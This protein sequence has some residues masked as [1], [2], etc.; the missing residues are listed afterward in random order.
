[1]F[2]DNFNQSVRDIDPGRGIMEH[3]RNKPIV[4]NPRNNSLERTQKMG[5]ALKKNV[6]QGKRCRGGH[7][8][9]LN[10]R[11]RPFAKQKVIF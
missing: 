7:A 10:G 5:F 2:L 8:K 9:P 11:G 1:M 4:T 6:H 3:L